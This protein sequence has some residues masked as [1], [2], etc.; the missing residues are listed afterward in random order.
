V[1]VLLLLL[2]KL[3]GLFWLLWLL[4]LSDEICGSVCE[5][6]ILVVDEKVVR[7]GDTEHL[8]GE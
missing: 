5:F 3:L 8:I 7:C 2:T 1:L 6:D 4:R